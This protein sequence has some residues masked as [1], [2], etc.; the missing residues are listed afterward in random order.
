MPPA[1]PGFRL[2]TERLVLRDWQGDADWAAFFR[3][4]NTP[5]VM[6][7]LGDLLDEAQQADIR[8]RMEDLA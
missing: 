8:Q 3:H 6:R 7:W 5:A 4:T 2:E 1:A